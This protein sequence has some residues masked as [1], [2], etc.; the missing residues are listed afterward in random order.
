MPISNFFPPCQIRY[1]TDLE[2][3]SKVNDGTLPICHAERK[4]KFFAMVDTSGM[5]IDDLE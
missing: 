4:N 3:V 1:V 2:L 5:L